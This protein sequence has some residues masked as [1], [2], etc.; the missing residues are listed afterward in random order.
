MILPTPLRLYDS[1]LSRETHPL[2][3]YFVFEGSPTA[4]LHLNIRAAEIHI[5]GLE[6]DAG[7]QVSSISP[8]DL[9]CASF[10][11]RETLAVTPDS[12]RVDAY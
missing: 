1:F 9:G 12:E 3:C 11:F 2:V 6:H 4:L 10:S 5:T 7:L 8:Q